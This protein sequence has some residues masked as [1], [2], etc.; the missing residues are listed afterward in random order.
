MATAEWLA[1]VDDEISLRLNPNILGKIELDALSLADHPRN[2]EIDQELIYK[3]NS[4][5][6][7]QVLASSVGMASHRQGAIVIWTYYTDSIASLNNNQEFDLGK[8]PILRTLI[9]T[10]GDLTQ[11]VCQDILHHPLADRILRGHGYVISQISEQFTTAIADYIEAKLRPLA[12]AAVSMVTVI[13]WCDPM[14]KLGKNLKLPDSLT[15]NC[16][17]IIIAAPVTVLMIWWLNSKLSFKL[18]SQ[19]SSQPNDWKKSAQKIGKYLLKFLESRVLQIVAISVIVI[20]LVGWLVI[21]FGNLPI[22]GQI[23]RTIRNIESFV[24][25]YLPISLISI[26][27]WIASTLGKI[28]FRYSFF[29]K[30]I[31]GRFIR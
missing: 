1:I 5:E 4:Q 12:I 27:K 20:L 30:L 2:E 11:K 31:F 13:A 15:S 22:E 19:L 29:L 3:L 10:D 28:F 6:L 7:L 17:S 26:R 25:P 8:R 21:T 9:H 24:E 16:W 23:S 14:Q 18:P